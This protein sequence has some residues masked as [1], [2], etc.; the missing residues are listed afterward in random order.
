MIMAKAGPLAT[1]D[2]QAGVVELASPGE[3]AFRPSLFAVRFGQLQSAAESEER[4]AKW[5]KDQ[6]A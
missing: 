1:A 3:S 6:T 5:E 2:W 4:K